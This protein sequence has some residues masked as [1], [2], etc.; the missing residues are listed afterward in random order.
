M[1]FG[2]I[3]R[4]ALQRAEMPVNDFEHLS[5][6][7]DF[8]NDVINDLWYMTPADF[9]INSD[10]VAMVANQ[11]TYVLNKLYDGMV[12]NTFRGPSANPR[13]FVYKDP[14]EFFRI[15]RNYTSVVGTPYMYTFGKFQAFD[16]QLAIA[17]SVIS[18]A[19]TL[20]NKTTSTVTTVNGSRKLVGA[21]AQFTLNDVGRRVI[22][23]SDAISYLVSEF[24]DTSTLILSEVYRG[25]SASG[26]SYVLG[27]VGVHANVQGIVGG[28]QDSE[29]VVLN[30]TTPVATTKTFTSITAVSKTDVTGGSVTFKDSGATLIATMAPWETDVERQT[31]IVWRIPAASETL[32]YRFSQKHPILILDSDRSLLPEKYHNLILFMTTAMLLEWGGMPIPS[33]L[34]SLITAGK[35]RFYN[36]CNDVSKWNTIPQATDADTNFGQPDIGNKIIDADFFS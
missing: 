11:D 36:D 13:C 4:R 16:A 7:R 25:V 28:Q 6:A 32:S 5:I 8:T 22:I 17:S 23:G 15:T 14:E 21:G 18:V 12:P 27:D 20:A 24:Q 30:G 33:M 9:R 29:D 10:T 3:I 2:L 26:A 19:S 31:I 34:A 1:N 35:E